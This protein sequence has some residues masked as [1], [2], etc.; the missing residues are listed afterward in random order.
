MHFHCGS[1][2]KYDSGTPVSWDK[3]QA[4][5]SSKEIMAF[6]GNHLASRLAWLKLK[7]FPLSFDPTKLSDDC[8]PDSAVTNT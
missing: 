4:I 8:H 6:A 7:S 5:T 3:P 1:I 2:A